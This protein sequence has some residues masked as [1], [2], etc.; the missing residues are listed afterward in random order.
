MWDK[1]LEIAS[2]VTDPISVA[3]LSLV[4]CAFLFWLARRSKH[5]LVARMFFVA[6]AAVAMVGLAPLL[7]T[8]YLATHGVYHI[9]I[10]VLGLDGQ[11]SSDAVITSSIGGEMKKA[12]RTWELDISP[13]T[14][15]NDREFTIQASVPNDFV[16][17]SANV[18]LEKGYF[19][20]ALV[21]L[22]PLSPVMVRGIVLDRHGEPIMGAT[23]AI[24]GYPELTTTGTMGNFEIPGHKASRQLVTVS[25][26]KGHLYGKKTAPAGDGFEI[27]V[28]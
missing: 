15:P 25:A 3:A 23:V 7:A 26:Q 10:Q 21:Q 17:G 20:K 18:V 27:I 22:K 8:T 28:E 13:Q 4:F 12:N 11:P 24:E 1:F 9:R 16:A 14:I 6:V 5:P 19:Q 2:R